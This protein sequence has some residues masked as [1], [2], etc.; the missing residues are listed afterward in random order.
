MKRVDVRPLTESWTADLSM[1]MKMSRLSFIAVNIAYDEH[2]SVES[3]EKALTKEENDVLWY[4]ADG[5]LARYVE[6]TITGRCSLQFKL[7]NPPE[8]VERVLDKTKDA[9]LI[10]INKLR[11][12]EILL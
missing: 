2:I 12:K 7:D 9:L 4:V 3:I 5:F 11:V 6:K 10:I 8:A 1:E